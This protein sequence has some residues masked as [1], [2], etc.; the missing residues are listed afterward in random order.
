MIRP[1]PKKALLLDIVPNWGCGSREYSFASNAIPEQAGRVPHQRRKE[2][3]LRYPIG[4]SLDTI[5]I[6][7]AVTQR[8]VGP[9]SLHPSFA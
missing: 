9:I 8:D 2:F 6:G 3:S 4:M 7:D 1:Y 5:P